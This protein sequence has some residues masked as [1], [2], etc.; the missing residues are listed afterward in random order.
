[1]PL[2]TPKVDKSGNTDETQSE[3]ISRC[4]GDTVM[5]KDYPDTKQRVAICYS[6]WDNKDKKEESKGFKI[7]IGG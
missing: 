7:H 4:A 2:P 1:M 3:F 6:Q 5:N